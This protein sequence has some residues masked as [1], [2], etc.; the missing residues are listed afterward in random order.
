M[1]PDSK[2][3]DNLA[4]RPT[5]ARIRRAAHDLGA[6]FHTW[7]ILQGLTAAQVAERAGLNRNTVS[8]IENG[9]IN[10]GF[11]AILN[12]ARALDQLDRLVSALDPY[13]SN[14]G[15]ARAEEALPRRIR[16]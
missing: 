7:R 4:T 12:V 1:Y 13:E 16:N 15:R 9:D 5:P 14:L 6:H 3:G 2:K 8:R 10:V 11:D